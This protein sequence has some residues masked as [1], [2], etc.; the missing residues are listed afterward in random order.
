MYVPF[1]IARALA[2]RLEPLG[3]QV[4]THS[5]TRSPVHPLDVDGYAVRSALTFPS[6]DEVARPSHVYNVRPGAYD[7]IVV[8]TDRP[9]GRDG[10]GWYGTDWDPGPMAAALATAAPVTV[11]EI[12]SARP[13][14]GAW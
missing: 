6:P 7:D 4:V 2:D 3:G 1:R 12:P 13:D 14:G 8:V 11:V 10:S 9:T 5:T